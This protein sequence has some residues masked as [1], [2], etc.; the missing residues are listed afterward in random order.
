DNPVNTFHTLRFENSTK[1]S[2]LNKTIVE[3]GSGIRV[4]DAR[5][6]MDSCIVRFNERVAQSGAIN[7]SGSQRLTITNSKIY[8]NAR[9]GVSTP[10]NGGRVV[11][12]NNWFFENGQEAGLHPQINLGPAPAND[13]L[14]VTG[15]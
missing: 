7:V 14:V 11:I 8:R 13:T 6:V 5:L 9:A 3:Y 4:L 15:N 12:K 2:R 1:T 10:A